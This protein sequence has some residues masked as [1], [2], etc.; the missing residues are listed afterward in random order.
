ML[1]S[2]V[3]IVK[4][5]Y[6]LKQGL[7]QGLYNVARFLLGYRVKVE[8]PLKQGLKQFTHSMYSVSNIMVKVE[9][10]LKQGLKLSDRCSILLVTYC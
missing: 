5:E 9:Y 3:E 8:Y 7:K 10:P 6:P 2:F 1:K 4:V